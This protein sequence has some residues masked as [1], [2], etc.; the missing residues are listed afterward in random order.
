[1]R[2]G[3]APEVRADFPELAVAVV[4]ARGLTPPG[5]DA[6]DAVV[7]EW[8]ARGRELLGDGTESDL[9]QIQA[10]RRAFARMGLKPTQYRC[11]SEALLRRLRLH[12]S[13]PRVQSLVDACNAISSAYGVP[14]AALDLAC[15]EGDLTVR[16]AA[17]DE[18][19]RTFAGTDEHPSPGEVIFVDA[20][21]HAHA[22]RWTNRQSGLSAVTDATTEVLI[23]SEA[24]HPG[25]AADVAAIGKAVTEVLAGLWAAEIVSTSS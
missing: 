22:R 16:R 24:L 20:A 13:L 18:V 2:F 23:V 7:E 17:G 6:V 8:T 9:P 15:V 11:A 5:R 14:V 21:G 3:H 4:H 19:Y 25:G 10:W 12:G 1:M